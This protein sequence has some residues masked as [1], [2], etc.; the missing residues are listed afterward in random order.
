MAQRR[1]SEEEAEELAEQIIDRGKVVGYFFWDSGA[2][3]GGGG[4]EAIYQWKKQFAIDSGWVE[5]QGPFDDLDD[6]VGALGLYCVSSA[7]QEV[8]L[9][10]VTDR[11]LVKRLVAEDLDSGHLVEVNGRQWEYLG[12][13]EWRR[14]KAAGPEG[15]GRWVFDGDLSLRPHACEGGRHRSGG[16]VSRATV[17]RCRVLREGSRSRPSSAPTGEEKSRN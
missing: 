12:G 16:R 4:R 13:G 3:N 14:V 1:Y 5:E 10:G 7:V 6:A 8:Y 9:S 11:A 17:S 15:R 2:L